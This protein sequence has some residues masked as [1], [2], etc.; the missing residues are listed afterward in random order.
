MKNTHILSAVLLALALTGCASTKETLVVRPQVVERPRL[1][2]PSPQPVQQL[3]FEWIVITKDNYEKKFKEIESK[4]G[5]VT[6][7]ALTPQGYQ[8]LSMNVSELRRFLQQHHAD[9]AALKK[10]YEASDT[11]PAEK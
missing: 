4:G 6:L 11:K 9:I 7:F 8:N 1:E 5:T 3:P 10:Y 2:V